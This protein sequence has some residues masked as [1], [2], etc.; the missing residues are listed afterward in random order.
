[1]YR[2]AEG[3]PQDYVRAYMWYLLAYDSHPIFAKDFIALEP[4]M[5]HE[6]MAEAA[7]F[8]EEWKKTK[9]QPR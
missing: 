4:H 1:M 3:M 2:E 9:Q 5:T 8:A 6:Q 7:K